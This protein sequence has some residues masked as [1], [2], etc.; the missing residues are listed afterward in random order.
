MELLEQLAQVAL[1]RDNLRLRSLAQDLMR[2]KTPFSTL[3]RPSSRDL[4]LLALSAALVELLAA[5]RGENPP[6]WTNEVGALDAPFFLIESATRM[7]RLRVLC[8]TQSPEPLRKRK[9]YA[10]PN[11]LQFA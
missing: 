9:L 10:P 2:S 7:Q 3:A 4:R 5:R 1:E 8:E 11:F 6:A